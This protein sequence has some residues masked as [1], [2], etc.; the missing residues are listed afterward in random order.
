MNVVGGAG[1][2][3]VSFT[4]SLFRSSFVLDLHQLRQSQ[5]LRYYHSRPDPQRTIQTTSPITPA[6]MSD[7]VRP[8]PSKRSRQKPL[9]TQCAGNQHSP[10]LRGQRTLTSHALE[11]RRS[12]V[13]GNVRPP[14][15]SSPP[16]APSLAALPTTS[17]PRTRSVR[18]K[19][20]TLSPT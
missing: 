12:S 9:L 14:A 11:L 2:T 1:A 3:R 4:H 15:Q 5:Q 16:S 8:H 10:V 19:P 18:P 20:R 7:K 13:N 6:I 17:R